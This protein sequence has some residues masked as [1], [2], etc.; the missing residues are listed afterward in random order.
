MTRSA[1]AFRRS[2]PF[3]TGARTPRRA[4]LR[5]ALALPTLPSCQHWQDLAILVPVCLC[6]ERLARDRRGRCLIFQAAVDGERFPDVEE[7]PERTDCWQCWQSWQCWQWWGLPLLLLL[8][9]VS[10]AAAQTPPASL[11]VLSAAPNGEIATLAEANEIRV[12]FSEPMVTAGR[13]PARVLAPFFRVTPAIPGTFRWSGTTILIFTPDPKRPL[14]Y[15]TKYDVTIDGTA[16]AVSGRRLGQPHRF[17][18][19]TPTVRLL[20]TNWYRRGG[21]AGAPMVILLR[22]NQPVR[23]ADVA[24]HIAARFEKHPWD[25]PTLPAEGLAR[26]KVTDPSSVQRFNAKVAATNAVAG[27]TSPV[28]LQLA[29][30]WDKKQFPPSR[31]LVVFETTTEVAPEA[32]VRIG[33]L[34]TI[35]SPAG[36]EKPSAETVY[37]IKVEHAFFVNGFQ[38]TRACPADVGNRVM[39]PGSGEGDGVRSRGPGGGGH[40]CRTVRSGGEGE[41]A[42]A[43]AG[44]RARRRPGVLAGRCRLRSAAAGADL[45]RHHRLL[46]A[47]GRRP[48]AR[49]HL[50]WGSVENWHERAFTSFGDGHGV[51]ERSGGL[52]LPFYARNMRTVTQWSQRVALPDL[53]PTIVRLQPDG[54]ERKGPAFSEAP[55]SS[56]LGSAGSAVTP[57]RI[58]SH[59]IDL[60]PA[61]GAGGGGLVWAAIRE[62]DPID[63][64]E[65][66]ASDDDGGSCSRHAGAGHRTSG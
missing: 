6:Q 54:E 21:R 20:N 53:M 30:E 28:A 60:A 51:W 8:L 35:P 44:L 7:C 42:A 59:G 15:A 13:I 55:A 4:A 43:A 63:R 41:H 2:S 9:T 47:R 10:P 62:G 1:N 56:A 27:S 46:S 3:T 11:R 12:V 22:F 64:A 65:R 36:V 39:L 14:P 50:G 16:T 52:L 19:T 61:L 48:D 23:P 24:P 17:S 31:D 33:I 49:L 5:A 26:L 40:G 38:C 29:T 25:V 37:V 34:P 45:Q 66:A 32:W 57:D 58:Q 18:F